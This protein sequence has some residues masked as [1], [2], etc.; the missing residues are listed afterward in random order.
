MKDN[1]LNDPCKYCRIEGLAGCD[2]YTQKLEILQKIVDGQ[3]TPKE[4]AFYNRIIEECMDCFCRQYC[5][6]ELAIKHLLRT[7]LDKKRVPIDLI[8]KIKSKFNESAP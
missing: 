7:K 1:V 6:Q 3:A 8:D 5:E 4:E 2:N